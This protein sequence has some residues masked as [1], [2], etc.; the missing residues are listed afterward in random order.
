[1]TGN[2]TVRTGRTPAP[3]RRNRHLPVVVA[4]VSWWLVCWPGAGS[5]LA[6]APFGLA[7]TITELGDF[8]YAVRMDA[9]RR[10]RRLDRDFVAPLLAEAAHAH[11]DSYVQF[12]AAVLL[13]GIGGPRAREFFRQALE[14]PNDRVRAA[15][16]E[17]AEH[18]P[19]P[20][21]A[22]RLLASLDRETSEFVRPSL[23]RALAAHD[24]DP[25]VREQLVRDIDRGEGFFR[26]TV[27]EALGERRAGYAVD[28][29]IRIASAEGPL[30]DDALVALGRIGDERALPV[31][32]AAQGDAAN[33]LQ[34]IVSASACL[35]GIDCAN[36]AR[37]VVQALEY[38]TGSGGGDQ[39]LLRAAATAAGALAAAG[40]TEVLDALVATGVGAVDPARAPLALAL[41][42][43]ALRDPAGVLEVLAGREDMEAVLLLLR[44]AF[45]MLDEDLAEERFYVSM[46]G[47]FWDERQI[48]GARAAA[49][50][51]MRV[52]EF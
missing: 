36:Q 3:R 12:R 50:A 46:Q 40:R 49:E 29:L 41:G 5:G 35:L 17:V 33:T 11:G 30:R 7:E 42:S 47:T 19:D 43:V 37:Y 10:I 34:P 20:A 28:A 9:S 24:G 13:S 23:L 21:L 32:A 22:P 6:Q 2:E 16:Y 18:D 27:I 38:G 48:A 31:I 26:A 4:V 44:D 1:M 39:V 45:D 15:A 8:D 14:A 25:A 51:A 52:L